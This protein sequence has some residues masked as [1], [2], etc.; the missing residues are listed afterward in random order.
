MSGKSRPRTLGG[1]LSGVLR[2]QQAWSG[3]VVEKGEIHV[4]PSVLDAREDLGKARLL[5]R[6][7]AGESGGLG[8]LS[9]IRG[10][11]IVIPCR[12]YEPG[13]GAQLCRVSN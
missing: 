7:W 10:G 3:L 5:R 11:Q 8:E 9:T 6:R 12:I 4:G 1:H 13:G 2:G